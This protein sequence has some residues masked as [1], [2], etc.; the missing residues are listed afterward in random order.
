MLNGSRHA[1]HAL[2]WEYGWWLILA[3]ILSGAVIG[4]G[5]HRESFLGGYASLRRR[6]VRLGH[7]ALVALGILNILFSLSPLPSLDFRAELLAS[8]ALVFGSLTMPLVCFLSAW[9]A[10]FRAFFFVPVL[11]L[12]LAMIL[13]IYGGTP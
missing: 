7:I 2:N 9:R 13:T 6:L 8:Q 11:S 5:F 12:G 3:G 1:L 4:L 10:E